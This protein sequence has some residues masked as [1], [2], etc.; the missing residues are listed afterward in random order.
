MSDIG[1]RISNIGFRK[2]EVRGRNYKIITHSDTLEKS[3]LV[4][5]YEL[6]KTYTES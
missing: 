2:G 6:P 1:Y 4:K 3:P 5:Y